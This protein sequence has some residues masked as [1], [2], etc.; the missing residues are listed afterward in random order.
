MWDSVGEASHTPACHHPRPGATMA[1]QVYSQVARV[2]ALGAK[3][4]APTPSARPRCA[5]PG[6]RATSGSPPD[7]GPALPPEQE[8]CPAALTPRW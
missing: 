4:P 6:P 7:A 1:A 3:R 8:A 5:A 2:T